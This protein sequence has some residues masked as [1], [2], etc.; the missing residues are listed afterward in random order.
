MMAFRANA[1]GQQ[2]RPFPGKKIT[3]HLLALIISV[4]FLIPAMQAQESSAEADA[5]R[6]VL[7][8]TQPGIQ[9]ADISPSPITG[10]Y[11]VEVRN[12]PLIYASADARYFIPG[13]LYTIGDQGGLINLGEIKRSA[14]RAEM[15]AALDES[16][17]IIFPASGE[18]RAS[19]TVFTDVDCQFC[20][21]F[22]TEVPALN[23]M[24]ISVRYVAFPRTG[25]GTD[26]HRKMISTWCAENP[27]VMYTSV[28]RGAEAPELDCDNPIAEHYQL[29]REIGVTGTPTL[30][31]ADGTA[32]PGY[33]PADR[34][35][36]Y[37][38]D[39]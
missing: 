26:T 20:R 37:I 33:I 18:E 11:Q 22:H 7:L 6:E 14:E 2:L 31:F 15:I 12:G 24:G 4:F 28:V 19:L 34:L 9:I 21:Q 29:G 1:G 25:L 38:F 10:L 27:R 35:A 23:R 36:S 17:M 32:L 39:E 5:I 13:D 8:R 16:G 3:V 30:V